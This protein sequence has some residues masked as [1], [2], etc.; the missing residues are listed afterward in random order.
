MPITETNPNVPAMREA[1]EQALSPEEQDR[2]KRHLR[3]LVEAGTGTTRSAAV[4]L[5][6][7]K[8]CRE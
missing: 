7:G 4:Y 2:F 3:P 8:K 5:I 1:I 6:A